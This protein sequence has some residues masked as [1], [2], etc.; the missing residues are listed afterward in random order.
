LDWS[1]DVCS[2]DLLDTLI[3]INKDMEVTTKSVGLTAGIVIMQLDIEIFRHSRH[4]QR[5]I[6]VFNSSDIKRKI[7]SL[8]NIFYAVCFLRSVSWHSSSLPYN[9]LLEQTFYL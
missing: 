5:N 3:L 7:N 1:S 2:S 9:Q 8:N 4:K 6:Q